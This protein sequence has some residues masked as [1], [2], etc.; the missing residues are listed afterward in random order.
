VIEQELL[1]IL[2]DII[3]AQQDGV[4]AVDYFGKQPQET[5]DDILAEIPNHWVNMV[6]MVGAVLA[7]YFLITAIPSLTLPSTPVD[8]G[9][10]LLTG[11]YFTLAA[12]GIVTYVGRT[13]YQK[14][15]QWG[16]WGWVVRWLAA[17]VLI[18]P[19]FLL[20]FFL[21]TP[22]RIYLPGLIGIALISI[23]LIA[24]AVVF[25]RQDDKMM[26]APFVPIVVM[27][28]LIG[29]VTRVQAWQTFLLKTTPGR[30]GLA[31][32]LVVALLLF[33][34]LI[35]RMLRRTKD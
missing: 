26:W 1:T 3:A 4:A 33:Y 6:K 25:W 23:L 17:C 27:M 9:T 10:L 13:T 34:G 22:W 20:T 21:K 31:G 5:A 8:I 18:A 35:W 2:T 16:R 30:I 15:H 24:L 29:I 11:V 28:A 7:G 19:G 14:Q 32:G 12:L